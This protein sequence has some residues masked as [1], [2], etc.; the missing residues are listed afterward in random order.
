MKS[1]SR[2]LNPASTRGRFTFMTIST[3]R[4]TSHLF[5]RNASRSSRLARLRSTALPILRVAVMPSRGLSPE[6]GKM[7]AVK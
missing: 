6:F 1:P 7:K 5:L 2:S 4:G 3:P